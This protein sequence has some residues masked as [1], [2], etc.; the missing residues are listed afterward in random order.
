[1]T[2][3]QNLTLIVGY[4]NSISLLQLA[5][6]YSNQRAKNRGLRR[7]ILSSILGQ[8]EAW[9]ICGFAKDV[10]LKQKRTRNNLS[11][12]NFKIGDELFQLSFRLVPTCVSITLVL[13]H[14]VDMID[15]HFPDPG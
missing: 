7:H 14:F 10:N 4:F 6:N 12:D 9:Q 5:R 13:S 15:N 3:P 1:M 8:Q 11:F 2:M